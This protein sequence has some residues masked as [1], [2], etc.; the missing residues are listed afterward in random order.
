MHLIS[1][2]HIGVKSFSKRLQG[3]IMRG[4]R[5]SYVTCA[6]TATLIMAKYYE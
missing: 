2:A 3:T 6:E 1:V 4:K 5:M